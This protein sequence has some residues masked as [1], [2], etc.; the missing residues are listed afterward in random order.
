MY[1]YYIFIKY[2]F[3]PLIYCINIYIYSILRRE[4]IVKK[5]MKRKWVALFNF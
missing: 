4:K 5:S 3:I 2:I 1:L